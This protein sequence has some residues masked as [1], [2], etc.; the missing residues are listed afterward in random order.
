M[1]YILI[2]CL[3]FS[4]SVSC[5]NKSASEPET[6]DNSLDLPGWKLL[7]NDE[8]DGTSIDSKKWNLEVNGNGGGNN[9][10]QY[11]T[12]RPINAS[13]E[14]N[15]AGEGKLVIRAT[16]ENYTGA[17]NVTKEYTSARLTTQNKVLARYSRVEVR[18]KLPGGKG[19]WP[20]IWM[21]G[22]NIG[23]V[24]WP[25]CGEVDIMENVGYDPY[26]ILGSVHTELKN[27]KTGG[28]FSAG[29][30]NQTVNTDFNIY[31]VEW[32]ADHIDFYFNGNKY[33]T[34]TK[35]G[36]TESAWPFDQPCF[37]LLNLAIGGD[38][39]GSQGIDNSIFPCR[40]E[41]DYVRVYEKAD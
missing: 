13:I 24:G 19:T 28:N 7:W 23:T 2:T 3:V 5:Q 32:F 29:M 33:G 6:K 11:Y 12:N 26:K 21:L 37:I 14:K 34:F 15:D 38:W 27:F 17:D 35:P 1:K 10:L 25:K 9:E 31:A 4:L 18:A 16:R 36:S 41:I 22:Q 40:F 39:G 8:F 20:A 30:T